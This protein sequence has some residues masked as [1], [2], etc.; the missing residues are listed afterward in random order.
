MHV[1][2]ASDAHKGIVDQLND[3]PWYIQ[4]AVAAALGG[5][6][7]GLRELEKARN[8]DSMFLEMA[9]FALAIASVLLVFQVTFGS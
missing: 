3:T 7:F 9:I 4:L 6:A 1:I 2:L 8:I 5:G